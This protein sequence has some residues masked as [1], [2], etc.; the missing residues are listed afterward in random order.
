VFAWKVTNKAGLPVTTFTVTAP[1]LE[2]FRRSIVLFGRT[3]AEYNLTDCE[4]PWET[5]INR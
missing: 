5:F 2:N 4:R 3:A 1:T